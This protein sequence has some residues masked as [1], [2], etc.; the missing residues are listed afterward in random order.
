LIFIHTILSHCTQESVQTQAVR[1]GT[2]TV[3]SSA[4][5]SFKKSFLYEQAGAPFLIVDDS[6]IKIIKKH[7]DQI[8]IAVKNPVQWFMEVTADGSENAQ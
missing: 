8:T 3:F 2:G 6:V 1:C 4:A 5:R 7:G